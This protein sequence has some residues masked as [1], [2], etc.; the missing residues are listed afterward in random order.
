M[1]EPGWLASWPLGMWA[2]ARLLQAATA[3][4]GGAW[5]PHKRASGGSYPLL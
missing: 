5:L 2:R 3:R 1:G 4:L